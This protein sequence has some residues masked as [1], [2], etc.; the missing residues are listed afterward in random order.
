MSGALRLM[1]P[2][3]RDSSPLDSF[4]NGCLVDDSR[5]TPSSNASEAANTKR[6]GTVL[7]GANVEMVQRALMMNDFKSL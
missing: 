7:S 6:Q 4:E 5:R 1:P 2:F 3:A